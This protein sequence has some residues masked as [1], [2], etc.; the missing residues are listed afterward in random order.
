MPNNEVRFKDWLKAAFISFLIVVLVRHFLIANYIV[1]G[2]SMMPT[3]EEGNRLIVNKIGY[4]FK[5]PSR[6]D[7]IVFHANSNEDYIKRVIGVP[8]DTIEY[9]DDQLFI[10]GEAVEEPYLNEYKDQLFNTQLTEDFTLLEKTGRSTVPEGYLFVMGDNRRHS[11]DSRHI[12]FINKKEV[13][14]I[15][16]LRYWPI[17]SFQTKFN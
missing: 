8:G 11:Y 3:I 1:H 16:D 6:F 5:E 2:E 7:L 17:E 14:G 15:V 9:K 13:V 10:N 12:G 4:E